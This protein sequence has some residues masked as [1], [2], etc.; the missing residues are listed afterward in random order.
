MN[1]KEKGGQNFIRKAHLGA[2]EHTSLLKQDK[3]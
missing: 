2:H 3:N 1:K